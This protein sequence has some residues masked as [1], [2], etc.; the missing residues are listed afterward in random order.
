MLRLGA[1]LAVLVAVGLVV[2]LPL[3]LL[4]RGSWG[5]LTNSDLD[6]AELANRAVLESSP[7]LAASRAV[8]H[9]G[10]Y[11]VLTA[12]VTLAALALLAA[13]RWR[14]AAYVVTVGIGASLLSSTLKAVVGRARPALEQAVATLPDSPSFPS[15]HALGSAA[16]YPAL[17]LAVW[18][19]LAGRLRR[20]AATVTLLVVLAVAASRVLLGVHYLSDVVAGAALG[21]AWA[22]ACTW[23][24]AR[25][26]EEDR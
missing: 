4:V 25:H 10:D 8:T 7:L 26:E 6:V 24:L 18:P 12:V 16:V 9:L 23:V 3:A 22:A 11:A 20:L 2:L 19:W 13:G 14:V 17:L 5:P 1:A 15:G 21:A